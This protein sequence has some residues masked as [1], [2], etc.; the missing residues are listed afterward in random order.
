MTILW[1]A[2]IAL[3]LFFIYGSYSTDIGYQKGQAIE[4]SHKTHSGKF[5]IKCLHC[6]YG[7]EKSPFSNIP[8]T[9]S[10]MACHIALGNENEKLVPVNFSFDE[11]AKI[12]WNNIYALPDYTHFN[13]ARHIRAQIDCSSCH[14][15]VE[16]GDTV[17]IYT[18]MTMKWCLDCHRQ[19][20]N[21]II[22]ARDISGIPTLELKEGE[23]FFRDSSISKTK[24]HYG[25]YIN[26]S[27][28]P[29]LNH[30]IVPVK[31]GKGPEHC[32]ACHY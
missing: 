16:T 26:Y 24:P 13:H 17:A 3:S 31:P 11:E 12:K 4:F 21:F 5:K 19:P 20:E 25:E 23:Q 14:G 8:S 1:L 29:Y 9:Y 18:D 2:I 6:H 22:K 15:E 7:A 28:K 10:C 27:A 32:S 30:F